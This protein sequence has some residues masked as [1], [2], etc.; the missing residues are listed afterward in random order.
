MAPCDQTAATN[1]TFSAWLVDLEK[2]DDEKAGPIQHKYPELVIS[3]AQVNQGTASVVK[4][5]D[6]MVQMLISIRPL[7][8]QLKTC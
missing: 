8:P 7:I 1:N 6:K 5:S 2:P 3:F 4:G